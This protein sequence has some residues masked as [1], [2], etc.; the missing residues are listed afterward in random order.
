MRGN[1]EKYLLWLSL[2]LTTIVL[3]PTAQPAAVAVPPV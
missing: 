2:G 1:P 3:R